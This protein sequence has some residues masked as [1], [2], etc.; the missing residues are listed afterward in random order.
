MATTLTTKEL[1]NMQ[2]DD[3]RKEIAE[4]RLIVGKMHIDVQMRSEKDTARFLREKKELARML[5]ILNEKSVSAPAKT[6]LKT[7]K[8]TAKV[9]APTAK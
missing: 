4:K 1:R 6:P 3:L 2:T 8:K 7:A 9:S 5:T